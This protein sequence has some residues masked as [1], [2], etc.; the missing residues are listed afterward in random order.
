MDINKVP[1][2]VTIQEQITPRPEVCDGLD[3]DCDWETDEDGVCAEGDELDAGLDVS[4]ADIV[5]VADSNDLVSDPDLSDVLEVTDEFDL[6]SDPDIT[7]ECEVGEQIITY[8]GFPETDGVGV[9]QPQ[10]EE[11][12]VTEAGVIYQ[13]IQE[14]ILPSDEICDELDNDCDGWLD[15][16]YLINNIRV[17]NAY[18]SSHDPSL[19]WNGS[20]YGISWTDDK[21]GDP[22]EIYFTL[23]ASDGT[24]IGDDRRIT[25]AL[26]QSHSSSLAWTDTEYG[27][28][29][30]DARTAPGDFG[31]YFTRLD[32]S[33]NKLVTDTRI[34]GFSSPSLVWTGSQY[35]LSYVNYN[36][37]GSEIYFNDFNRTRDVVGDILRITYAPGYSFSPSLV[38]N[39]SEYG[40]SWE[41]YRSGISGIYFSLLD[42][43]G[44]K[45][46]DDVQLSED[47]TYGF[48]PSL[49]WTD[50]EY[51]ISWEQCAE[52]ACGVGY[53][54]I[55]FTRV[56]SDG[57]E[58]GD[59][60][61][62][63]S[64]TGTSL[65][66]GNNQYGI[67]WMDY[68]ELSC[69]AYF[70]VLDVFGN[71]LFE[72]LKISE[73]HAS[74]CGIGRNI[75]IIWNGSEYGIVWGDNRNGI[76]NTEIYFAR[77]GVCN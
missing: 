1:S 25:N 63:S 58:I 32:E 53:S 27:L 8:S 16:P 28:T 29:W 21:D 61:I 50:S 62:I 48:L 19:V 59:E 12:Q 51:G 44:T 33:G 2:F 47:I 7:Y 13:I 14:E 17:T 40:L 39:G 31:I 74:G 15:E 77:V 6:M 42:E 67:T 5:D 35:G 46:I 70:T 56:N 76:L 30:M 71:R 41:D 38:Y 9:C 4:D 24:E 72:D 66:W 49:T 65:A 18:G 34:S 55:F 26:G 23:L 22:F 36:P 73:G 75:D 37:G 54:R 20:N 11:C 45:I 69:N 52:H 64:G 3:N 60:I 68:Q 57:I 10:I 43:A